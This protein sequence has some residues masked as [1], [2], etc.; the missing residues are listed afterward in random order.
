MDGLLLLDH[1]YQSS[2]SSSSASSNSSH[3]CTTMI[4]EDALPSR[5]TALLG[6]A[7]V[8]V[9]F[10]ACGDLRGF[11][12]DKSYSLSTSYVYQAPIQPP[13]HP[14]YFTYQTRKTATVAVT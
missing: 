1:K 13:L 2:S 11:D 7:A 12:P 10:V 8:V 4:E 14:N 9:P 6:P 3:S 5:S